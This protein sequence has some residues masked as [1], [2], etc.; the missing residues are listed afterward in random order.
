MMGA[1]S[2][3]AVQWRWGS[4]AYSKAN[5]AG[6]LSIAAVGVLMQLWLVDLTWILRSGIAMLAFVLLIVLVRDA[7][8]RMQARV[9]LERVRQALWPI[10][11][12]E[13]KR[14]KL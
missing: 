1:V 14:N 10:S 3:V 2:L 6:V 7:E 9:V 13:V 5:A 8:G 12:V 11:V 4:T